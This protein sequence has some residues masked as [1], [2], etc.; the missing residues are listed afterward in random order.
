M[1]EDYEA[2][3]PLD[4]HA[5]QDYYH[6]CISPVAGEERVMQTGCKSTFV[7]AN[8]VSRPTITS[9]PSLRL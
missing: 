9:G 6:E 8:M 4:M 3:V 5:A 2:P 7:S 1:P